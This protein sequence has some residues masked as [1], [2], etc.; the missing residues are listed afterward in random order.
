MKAGLKD[1]IQSTGYWRIHIRPLAPL[2]ENPTLTD[3]EQAVSRASVNI[4]G[5]DF[6]VF[7]RRND[8]DFGTARDNDFVEHWCDVLQ[9]AEFWRCYKSSQF[10][11]YRALW[12]DFGPRK[13]SSPR[14]E[15]KL[16]SVRGA[17][18]SLIEF[19]EFAHRMRQEG[20]YKDG[21]TVAVELRNSRGRR[22]WV[23]E[24]NRM[25]FSYPRQTQ[26]EVLTLKQTFSGAELRDN[27]K[28]VT[29]EQILTF[30]DLFG[31]NPDP[32]QIETDQERFY[33]RDFR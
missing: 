28:E 13:G 11:A 27:H 4:R 26:A 2:A 10:I 21:A 1:K 20:F 33:R 31:W 32:A 15:G 16:L 3:I 25:P 14:P 8:E 17:M 23:D 18:W 30:F 7:S 12:E 19:F 5:W 29:R 6:P 24:W 9:Y 22:L